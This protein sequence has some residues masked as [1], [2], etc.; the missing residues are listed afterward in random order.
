MTYIIPSRSFD[1]TG[2]P[3]RSENMYIYNVDNQ[4]VLAREAYIDSTALFSM[5]GATSILI[6]LQA[7]SSGEIL[8]YLFLFYVVNT[9]KNIFDA[10][11]FSL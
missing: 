2:T 5:Y 1:L 4:N 7:K 8:R 6:T 3:A 11:W 9:Y 10:A